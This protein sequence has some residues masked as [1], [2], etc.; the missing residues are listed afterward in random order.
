MREVDMNGKRLIGV[1]IGKSWLD[2]AVEGIEPV[3]RYG[4][5]AAGIAALVEKLDPASDIVVFERCGGWERKLEAALADKTVAWAVVHSQRVKAFRTAQGIKAKTDRIDAR[6]L[7]D[8]GRDRLN[9]GQLRLGRR[10]DITLDVLIA[11]QRQLKAMLHAENCRLATAALE[12]VGASIERMVAHLEEELA[13]IEAELVRYEHGHPEPSFKEEVLCSQIGVAKAT[14]R[15][16]LAE[17]PELGRLDRK[18]IT[19]LG[20]L[21]PRVHESGSIRKCRGLAPGR[22]AIKVILFN[23]ARTAM[24]CDP[25]I[26]QFCSGLR[27]RGK[28]GKVIMVAVMRKMLVRLNAL[29]RDAMRQA[30]AATA[31]Q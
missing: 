17:L 20:G 21:A 9:A 27:A 5:D 28:P 4:N 30:P 16:L 1:D 2:A 3:R 6:L 14:A 12:A 7:R 13:A 23:P 15:S 8:F 19:A 22:R 24:R 10:E 11:R 26:K 25:E 29:L 18:E 31:A